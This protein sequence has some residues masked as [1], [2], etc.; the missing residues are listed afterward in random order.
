MKMKKTLT[1][2]ALAVLIASSIIVVSSD[3][4][5]AADDSRTAT[6]WPEKYAIRRSETMIY[7]GYP[8]YSYY[9][10]VSEVEEKDAEMQRYLDGEIPSFTN[11]VLSYGDEYYVYE[12]HSSFPTWASYSKILVS[13]SNITSIPLNPGRY[14]FT[15]DEITG[16]DS[17][18]FN[19]GIYS[20]Y[21]D[22]SNRIDNMT[23]G[24]SYT[25]DVGKFVCGI[26]RTSDSS[27]SVTVRYHVTPDIKVEECVPTM[28]VQTLIQQSWRSAIIHLDYALYNAGDS[29]NTFLIPYGEDAKF[30]DEVVK[31]QKYYVYQAG[32]DVK[33]NIIR[34]NTSKSLG[35]DYVLYYE[36]T[37][38]RIYLYP[39]GPYGSIYCNAEYVDPQNIYKVYADGY[40]TFKFGADFDSS[41]YSAYLVTKGMFNSNYILLEPN[42]LYTIDNSEGQ[43]YSLLVIAKSLSNGDPLNAS[44]SIQTVNVPVAD[45]SSDIFAVTAIAICVIVF[46]L[47]FISGRKPSWSKV[48]EEKKEKE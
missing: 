44:I 26:F 42:V 34:M 45:E 46:G 41:K 7:S 28:N 13:K 5:D 1:I 33:Y 35:G 23:K 17:V 48:T 10:K 30:Y 27:K 6:Y 8:G 36:G 20:E 39:S 3:T 2:I 47:L 40:S 32:D 24:N 37:N 21:I 31:E 43:E 38:S 12:T 4:D 9:A 29:N 18:N 25:I 19:Y 22:F 16:S 15:I 11:S 14:T